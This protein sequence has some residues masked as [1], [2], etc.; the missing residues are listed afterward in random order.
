VHV[1]LSY[2][3]RHRAAMLVAHKS[4]L[5]APSQVLTAPRL[6]LLSDMQGWRS[7]PRWR[8]PW[9]PREFDTLVTGTVL[10]ASHALVGVSTCLPNVHLQG[11]GCLL[12]FVVLSW[13]RVLLQCLAP[14][15]GVSPD[16]S[17]TR[18]CCCY[19]ALTRLMHALLV[20]KCLY[21]HA[22]PWSK[23]KLQ[24][25][26]NRAC[27]PSTPLPIRHLMHQPLHNA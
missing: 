4:R 5:H 8:Q 24:P 14:E 26:L 27:Q 6:V 3:P 9:Q 7:A 16:L 10:H 25:Q 2:H 12:Y 15:K 17:L 11:R 22:Q 1:N 13:S 20:D 18:F 21:W 23:Y 19:L